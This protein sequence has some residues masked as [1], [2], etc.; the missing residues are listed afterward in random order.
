MR[1]TVTLDDD[2]AA[3]LRNI[4][5]QLK[6]PFKSVL[7]DAVRRGVGAARPVARPKRF[8]VEPRVCRLRPGFD[9]T[10]FNQLLDEL[11]TEAAAERLAHAK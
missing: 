2:L 8:V 1:T 9:D 3:E 11:D 10:R 6:K 5:H 4:A 7:N